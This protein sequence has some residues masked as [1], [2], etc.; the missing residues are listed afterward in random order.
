MLGLQPFIHWKCYF[1]MCYFNCL[2]PSNI[3]CMQCH[4]DYTTKW[5]FI[6]IHQHYF[7]VV[8]ISKQSDSY[9]ITQSNLEHIQQTVHAA[10]HATASNDEMSYER[11]NSCTSLQRWLYSP[12]QHLCC[13]CRTLT[14]SCPDFNVV[15]LL[16]STLFVHLY[17][18]SLYGLKGFWT[19]KSYLKA[20]MSLY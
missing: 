1:M 11:L 8:I 4:I 17:L 10:Q 6:F 15:L 3:I 9:W 13:T 14:S 2:S 18:F 12:P 20:W 7:E 19:F 5:L 16:F